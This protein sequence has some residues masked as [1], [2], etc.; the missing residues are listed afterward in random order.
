VVGGKRERPLARKGN[1][2]PMP[3][4]LTTN[5][6]SKFAS[7]NQPY[8]QLAYLAPANDDAFYIEIVGG[9]FPIPYL[10]RAYTDLPNSLH[11]GGYHHFC[12]DVV[13]VKKTIA[14]LRRRGVWIVQEP[15]YLSDVRRT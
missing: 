7:M 13:S 15:F 9:G 14:E 11:E 8:Q 1:N 2:M 10:K 12:I 5:P 4:N 6:D 3:P